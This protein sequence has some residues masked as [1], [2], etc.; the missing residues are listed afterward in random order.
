MA[1]EPLTDTHT[2]T[3]RPTSADSHSQNR[4]SCTR[5]S[6]DRAS[7]CLSFSSARSLQR[8]IIPHPLFMIIK[9]KH[10]QRIFHVTQ[11]PFM[12]NTRTH[13]HTHTHTHINTSGALLPSHGSQCNCIIIIMIIIIK[14]NSFRYSN[15]PHFLAV[16]V[17]ALLR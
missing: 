6:S 1:R 9:H 8:A 2:H 5:I 16:T 4:R 12:H 3:H 7:P 13:T 11:K 15:A 17:T 10:M 14:K